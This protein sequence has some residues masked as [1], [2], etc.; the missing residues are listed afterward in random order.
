MTE[1]WFHGKCDRQVLFNPSD[2]F[3][4]LCIK[5]T[6]NSIVLDRGYPS[7]RAIGQGQWSVSRERF[8]HLHWRLFPFFPSRGKGLPLPNQ[9]QDG[10]R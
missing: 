2:D 5:T 7:E 10:W 9:N 6:A 1:E 3:E 4:I 8:D